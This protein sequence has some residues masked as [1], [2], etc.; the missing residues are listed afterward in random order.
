[1]PLGSENTVDDMRSSLRSLL[2]D[3]NFAFLKN[4]LLVLDNVN[5]KNTVK[6]FDIGLKTLIT[7]RQK[8]MVK[9]YNNTVYIPVSIFNSNNDRRTKFAFLFVNSADL[10]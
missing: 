1:M 8:D 10:T 6:N 7:T 5:S 4:S 3:P 9:T 2:V